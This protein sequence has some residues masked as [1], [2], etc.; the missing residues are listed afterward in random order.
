VFFPYLFRLDCCYPDTRNDKE[1]IFRLIGQVVTVSLETVKIVNALPD[2]GLPRET[3]A[4]ATT[5]V[6]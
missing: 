6:H 5:A 3:A 2:L 4:K 1:Y